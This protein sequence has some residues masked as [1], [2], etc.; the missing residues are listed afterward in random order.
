[1]GSKPAVEFA[2]AQFDAL[3]AGRTIHPDIVKSVLQIAALTGGHKVF[4]WLTRRLQ[5]SQ[6]EHERMNLLTA[7]GAFKNRELIG[8]AQQYVLEQVPARNQFVPVVSMAAIKRGKH[9]Y[10]EKPLT[11]SIWEARVIREAAAKAMERS[12]KSWGSGSRPSGW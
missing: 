7:L 11:H 1:M 8:K 5:G 3:T 12:S 4:N 9:V 2:R 6:V 10:C